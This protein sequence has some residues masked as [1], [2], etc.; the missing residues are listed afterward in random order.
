MEYNLSLSKQSEN[1]EN[2]EQNKYGNFFVQKNNIKKIN[3]LARLQLKIKELENKLEFYKKHEEKFNDN[4]DDNSDDNIINK[5]IEI[6]DQV[7]LILDK[8]IITKGQFNRKSKQ[9]EIEF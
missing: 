3:K 2:F 1:F 7:I 9:I 4:S 5:T 6:I 8:S